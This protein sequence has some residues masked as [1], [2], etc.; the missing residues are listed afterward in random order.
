MAGRRQLFYPSLVSELEFK[1]GWCFKWCFKW[2][3]ASLCEVT[4][5][6]SVFVLLQTGVC[7]PGRKTLLRL[8]LPQLPDFPI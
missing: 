4:W 6:L 8:T 7:C 5:L 3:L 2:C 1:P